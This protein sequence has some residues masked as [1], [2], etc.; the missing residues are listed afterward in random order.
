[1]L[2]PHRR[3]TATIII[4]S[5][6]PPPHASP[7]GCV[8][9]VFAQRGVRLLFVSAEDGACGLAPSPTRV[10][11]VPGSA[12]GCVGLVVKMQQDAFGSRRVWLRDSQGQPGGGRRAEMKSLDAPLLLQTWFADEEVLHL[13]LEKHDKQRLIKKCSVKIKYE[14]DAKAIAT[15]KRLLLENSQQERDREWLYAKQSLSVFRVLKI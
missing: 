4:T 11:L 14:W 10:R 8:G 2:P 12:Q 7:A 15:K 5:S 3:T 13:A 6:S 1:M 9:L